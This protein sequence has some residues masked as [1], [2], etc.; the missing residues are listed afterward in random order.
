LKPNFSVM[1]VFGTRP[2][3]IK[4]APIIKEL[5]AR[6]IRH[7]TCVTGQHREMLRQMLKLFDITP[8][9]DLN[10]MTDGQTLEDVTAWVLS[11]MREIYLQAKPSMVLVQGDTNSAFS[12]AMGAF[13]LQIPVGHVEAGLRTDEMYDPFPEEMSRRLLTQLASIHFAP[14]RRALDNLLEDGV[15]TSDIHVTGNTGVDA[16]L[17][18]I[19]QQRPFESESLRKLN[20]EKLV[21]SKRLVVVTTHRR[22][23]LGKRMHNIFAAIRQ[24]AVEEKDCQFVF[25]VHLNPIVQ[26]QAHELLDELP[27]V[28]MIEPLGYSDMAR[29]MEYC[30]FIM[31]DSGGIQEEAPSLNKPVLVL[32]ETTE[33]GE[34]IDAGTAMLAGGKD[35]QVIYSL[36]KRLL[37][38]ERTYQTMANAENPY[39]DGS[40]GRKI[41]DWIESFHR[42]D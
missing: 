42:N 20:I 3:A 38:D 31:T 17:M 16:L 33:R 19:A 2:E 34:G 8:D 7:Y 14:T 4:V 27:N 5:E 39:G 21:K 28:H 24:L 32:R 25:P 12:A 30:Y 40:A 11:G 26:K 15:D 6:N 41:V 23:N 22:E 37:H 13:Y 18:T 29:L 9:F 36:A 35:Q 10:I 1:T